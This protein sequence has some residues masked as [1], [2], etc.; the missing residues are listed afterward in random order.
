MSAFRSNQLFIITDWVSL[1]F[2]QLFHYFKLTF[3]LSAQTCSDP[4]GSVIKR[5]LVL[6]PDWLSLWGHVTPFYRRSTPRGC[7]LPPWLG[8][9]E[10]NNNLK[11][12]PWSSV[13]NSDK[14]RQKLKAASFFF[15]DF[16]PHLP[17]ELPAP[18]LLLCAKSSLSCPLGVIKSTNRGNLIPHSPF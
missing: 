8:I 12:T 13:V 10:L 16:T 4:L 3:N 17:W 9:S 11:M 1:H 18:S 14:F 2:L 15:L 6:F 7:S 5:E